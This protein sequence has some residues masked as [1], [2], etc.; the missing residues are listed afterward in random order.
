MN[1]HKC[2]WPT[3]TKPVPPKLWGCK[4]HWFKLPK[5]LR[6][7][8]WL[9]YRPGQEIDKNPSQ[10]YL[11]VADKIQVWAINNPDQGDS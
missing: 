7:L 9:H 8:I 11:D 6:D 5:N 1:S 2:H 4:R 3:C 10:E